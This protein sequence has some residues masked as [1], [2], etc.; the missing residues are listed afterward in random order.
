MSRSDP[1]RGTRHE[2]RSVS[3][4]ES[5]RC[6][7]L[8]TA[9][10]F[11]AYSMCDLISTHCLKYGTAASVILGQSHQMFVEMAFD[12]SL[13]F[14]DEAE[15]HAIAQQS[16]RG[17]YRKRPGIP[18]WVQ[19]ARTGVELFQPGLAPGE[20]VGFFVSCFQ[21]QRTSGGGA[22]HQGLAVVE[23]LRCDF[24]GVIHAHEGGGVAFLGFR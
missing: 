20:M 19:Q 10:R 8:S 9:R 7:Q 3:H 12:L 4:E 15:A 5:H 17:T 1:I 16:S 2:S 21:Q 24:A 22:G 18:E 23:G 14:D 6:R 13:G 11:R